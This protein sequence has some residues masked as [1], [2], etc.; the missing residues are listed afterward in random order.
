MHANKIHAALSALFCRISAGSLPPAAPLVHA[1]T[2]L[3]AVAEERQIARSAYAKQLVNQHQVVLR[4]KALRMLQWGISLPV[5]CEASWHQRGT[6][7]P[8][9]A[10]G[11]LQPLASGFAHALPGDVGPDRMAAV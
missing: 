9:V 2:F 7:K 8:M 11:S 1:H 3:L 4:R 10:N 6:I 5:A